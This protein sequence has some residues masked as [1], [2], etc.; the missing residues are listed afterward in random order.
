MALFPEKIKG[1]MVAL[2]TAN[3]DLP[4]SEICIAEF[5]NT[6]DIWS[7]DFWH[8]WKENLDPHKLHIRRADSDQLEIGAPPL[9]TKKG[10]L[11]VYSHIQRYG[12]PDVVFGIEAILLDLKNPRKIIGRTKGPIMVNEEYY[13]NAGHASHIVFPSGAIVTKTGIGKSKK[14]ILEIYYNRRGEPRKC[15]AYCP[16]Y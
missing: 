5:E 4:P 15:Q 16:F 14:E 7:S 3:S 10:W 9:K 1:K 12:S 11:L 6:E 8:K 2:L 13:E